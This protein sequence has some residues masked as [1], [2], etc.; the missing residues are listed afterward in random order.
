MVLI[1]IFVGLFLI[2]VGLVVQY[3]KQYDFI[4]G[5]NSLEEHKKKAFDIIRYARLFG[6]TFYIMGSALIFFTIIFSLLGIG[7]GYLVGIMLIVIPTG[8][9]YLNL[10]GEIIKQKRKRPS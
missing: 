6:I 7:S 4:A 5:Y 3:G 2:S 8:V 10:I 1:E 9:V